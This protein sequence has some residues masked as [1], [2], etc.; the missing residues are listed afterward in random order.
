MDDQELIKQL[1]AENLKLKQKV[2][3]L[4]AELTKKSSAPARTR[5]DL[6]QVIKLIQ[7]KDKTLASYAAELEEK[8][9]E[10]QQTVE[11]LRRKNEELS[12]WITSLRLYQDIFENEPSAMI[13][14]NKNGCLI[15]FNKSAVTIVG[16]SLHGLLMH[17]V[18][19]INFNHIDPALAHFVRNALSTESTLTKDLQNEEREV[20]CVA[21]P[22]KS[23][24]QLRGILLKITVKKL[25]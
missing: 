14:F 19:E 17:P 21:I 16:E 15:L 6:S 4:E 9:K 12:L 2:K 10:L 25:S 3:E 20:S 11:E 5:G 23:A 8:Q 24:Q 1:A 7:R 18:E 13:G 22:L